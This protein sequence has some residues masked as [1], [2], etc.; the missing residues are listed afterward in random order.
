MLLR[1]LVQQV[2]IWTMI[3]VAS[4]DV[5]SC[6]VDLVGASS[7]LSFGFL[8]TMCRVDSATFGASTVATID[9]ETTL[10]GF[11]FATLAL[12]FLLTVAF[13]LTS[14]SA[15]FLGFFFKPDL[16]SCFILGFVSFL[17]PM[18][19]LDMSF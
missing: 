14:A 6:E 11:I 13:N 19:A 7:T 4:L 12:A 9:L 5:T 1:P 17:Q 10:L 8:V 3:A 15:F 2:V 18:N 16:P